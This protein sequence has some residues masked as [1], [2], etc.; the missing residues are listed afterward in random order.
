[1]TKTPPIPRAQHGDWLLDK[2][3]S[4]SG[5]AVEGVDHATNISGVAEGSRLSVMR[6]SPWGA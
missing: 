5:A 3:T 6:A 2:L 1:M 4:E